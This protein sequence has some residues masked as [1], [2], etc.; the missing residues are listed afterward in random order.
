MRPAPTVFALLCL[1]A[2]GGP[3][4]PIGNA[5]EDRTTLAHPLDSK[6]FSYTGGAQ[7]FKVPGGV[8]QVTVIARGAG[9]A[10]YS[11]SPPSGDYPGRGGRVYAVVPVKPGETLRVLVGGKGHFKIG[12]FNGG[13]NGGL[14]YE[15]GSYG[16]G[17]A[18]DVREGGN[19]LKHRIIVAGGGGG[20]GNGVP[21]GYGSGGDGGGLIG[22]RGGSGG[23]D[24]VDGG[25][26]GGGTQS[27]GG[28]GGTGGKRKYK[29][30]HSG[31]PGEDGSLGRG[32]DGGAGGYGQEEYQGGS[33]GGGAGGGYYG[34]GGGGGGA[35]ITR[36]GNRRRHGGGGGGGG[37]GSSYVEA[38]AIKS[39]IW[40]GWKKANADGQVVI[41]W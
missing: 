21:Y 25:G 11:S 4:V 17:G 29:K 39:R 23:F 15:N 38:K 18:S 33:G 32:G 26:G 40:S 13:G 36:E 31:K 5:I 3:G 19:T 34:G 16:G 6:T 2:C 8:R 7:S 1:C 14:D 28:S 30:A 20:G 35:S 27:A 37:G 41:S 10:G 12:G 9:G 24:P 22:Q